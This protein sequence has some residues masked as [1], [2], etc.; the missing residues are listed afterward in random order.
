[1]PQKQ[2]VRWSVIQFVSRSYGSH[3]IA[4]RAYTNEVKMGGKRRR[5]DRTNK[6]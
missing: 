1:M 4:S 2:V 3:L 6:K 5:Y